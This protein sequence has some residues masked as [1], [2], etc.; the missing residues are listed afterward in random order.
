MYTL[1]IIR[2]SNGIFRS[3]MVHKQVNVKQLAEELYS[4]PCKEEYSYINDVSD[5]ILPGE[6]KTLQLT[7]EDQ[8]WICYIS[9]ISKN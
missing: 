6:S 7:G 5:K 2:I 8:H 9:N 3:T 1:T 4:V